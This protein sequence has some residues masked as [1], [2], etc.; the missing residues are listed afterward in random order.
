MHLSRVLT[1]ASLRSAAALTRPRSLGGGLL[2][3]LRP[4]G[5]ARPAP[6]ARRV[7]V[8]LLQDIYRGVREV[9]LG[10][11]EDLDGLS[12]TERRA[13]RLAQVDRQVGSSMSTSR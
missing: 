7:G 6:R 4:L 2:A 13:R 8:Q 11:F 9:L 1:L 12:A 10:H 5:P 3:P